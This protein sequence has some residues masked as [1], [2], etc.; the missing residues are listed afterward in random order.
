MKNIKIAVLIIFVIMLTSFLGIASVSAEG[1]NIPSP[2]AASSYAASDRS[3]ELYALLDYISEYNTEKLWAD[4]YD[5]LKP[6]VEL[7]ASIIDSGSY[8]ADYSGL[9]T[10]VDAFLPMEAY[11]AAR[12]EHIH[13]DYLENEVQKYKQATHYYEKYGICLE[14]KSYVE[15]YSL[16]ASSE[17][18]RE[19]FEYNNANLAILTSEEE[20]YDKLLADNASSFVDICK[21]I[22]VTR[23]YSTLSELVEEAEKLILDMD[24]SHPGVE[25]GL[26][27]YE[28]TKE[29][30]ESKLNEANGFV[31]STVLMASSDGKTFLENVISANGY[32]KNADFTVP[33]VLDAYNSYIELTELYDSEIEAYNNELTEVT[34]A[35]ASVS[36][37]SK[38]RGIHVMLMR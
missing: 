33:G 27:L 6:Y 17:R 18:A 7:A 4:N 19:I 25:A 35:V 24:M 3:D 5:Y 16:D 9:K 11:F 8:N 26:S 29:K 31:V 10:L 14:I 32:V 21:E 30:L 15:R 20:S 38:T 36:A 12:E 37:N 28:K 2:T 13:M 23:D 1:D 34:K 22:N